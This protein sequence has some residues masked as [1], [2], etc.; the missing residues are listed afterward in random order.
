VQNGCHLLAVAD[1]TMFDDDP[2]RKAGIT[3]RLKRQRDPAASAELN[4]I[5]DRTGFVHDTSLLRML[6][7]ARRRR[8]PRRV[9]YTAP[10]GG[11]RRRHMAPVALI[12]PVQ[13]ARYALASPQPDMAQNADSTAAPQHP[14][15][16]DWRDTVAA[17]ARTD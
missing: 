13:I 11:C 14:R 16:P 4:S 15:S 3:L 5:G 8:G 1:V 10:G 12:H 17:S 9:D 2:D 7:R 6:S